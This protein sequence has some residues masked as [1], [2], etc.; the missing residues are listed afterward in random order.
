MLAICC[1]LFILT[2]FDEW[3]K[4][5][6]HPVLEYKIIS[7]YHRPVDLLFDAVAIVIAL[8]FSTTQAVRSFGWQKLP[9]AKN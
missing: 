4:M 7:R 2:G 5:G 1:R 3:G 6:G 8:K 9:K